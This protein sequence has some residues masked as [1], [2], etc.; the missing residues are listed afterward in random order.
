MLDVTKQN[1][2]IHT[3][4]LLNETPRNFF[5]SQMIKKKL[6]NEDQKVNRMNN[7]WLC[8]DPD[9]VQTVL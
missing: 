1:R 9:E 6:Q 5:V 7:S 8:R 3:K 4:R 2:S